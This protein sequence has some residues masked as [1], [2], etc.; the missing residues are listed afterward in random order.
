MGIEGGDDLTVVIP[1]RDRA[2]LLDEAIRSVLASPLIRTPRQVVVV[3]DSSADCTPEVAQAY[4]V[5]Y[6]RVAGGSPSSARNAG[7]ALVQTPF[8]AF[9]DDDDCWLPG[10]LEPHLA[11]LRSQ[12]EAA[13]AYGRVQPTNPDLT[14]FGGPMPGGT[15]ASGNVLDFLC[16][17]SLQV[18]SI[19][20]RTESIRVL[21][22]FDETIRYGEDK[23]LQVR[24][25]AN[26]SVIGVDFIGSLFRQRNTTASDL[27]VRWADYSDSRRRKRKLKALHIHQSRGATFKQELNY[28]GNTSYWLCVDSQ[29][30]AVEGRYRDSLRAMGYAVRISPPHALLRNRMLW[31]AMLR[32]ATDRIVKK[33]S[34]PARTASSMPANSDRP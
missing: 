6:L 9:L 28:R 18:G 27:H 20:F 25:A 17:T 34:R 22:G 1:T 13:Y 33:W 24:L 15:L 32:L 19:A 29:L 2:R 30:A 12:P 4:G 5:R 11:A 16:T 31:H 7:L 21:G 3:D 23:D 14:P 8:V 26:Y 10:N